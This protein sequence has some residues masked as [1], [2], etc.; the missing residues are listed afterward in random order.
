MIQCLVTRGSGT[1][2]GAY[3]A[4]ITW[5]TV[6]SLSLF[7]ITLSDGFGVKLCKWLLAMSHLS[8]QRKHLLC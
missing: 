8:V 7:C 2:L 5:L 6:K 3:Y 1:N 4:F